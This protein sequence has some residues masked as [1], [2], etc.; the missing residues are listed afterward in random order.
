MRERVK[1]LLAVLAYWSGL[2]ALFY[3]LNRRSKRI[4]T[5]HNV[6]PDELIKW[7]PC[8]G[9]ADSASDFRRV[10]RE[11]RKHFRFSV[12]FSDASTL[13]ITFDDGYLNQY[14]IAARILREEGDIPAVLFAT[15]RALRATCPNEALIVDQLTHWVG[16]APEI[17]D[18]RVK[19]VRE[20][21]PAYARDSATKGRQLML[22]LDAVFPFNA[23]WEKLPKEYRRLRLTGIPLNK[24]DELRC[25]GWK[26]GWHTENHYPLSFL[27]DSDMRSEMKN[28][29]V[30]FDN[31]MSYP[32]GELISVDKRV[33]E[34]AAALGYDMAFSNQGRHNG[35]EGRYFYPREGVPTN[36]YLLHFALSGFKQFIQLRELRPVIILEHGEFTDKEEKNV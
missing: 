36:K 7:C 8:C 4:L 22:K 9:V 33:T 27:E 19:W 21:R 32:Y 25:R 14:E 24:L 23:I 34:M 28:R 17:K 6:I 16:L 15:G 18:R 3:W 31:I 35:L 11:L 5:F 13:T 29:L 10:I 20:I 12:D 26:I 30:G 1:F 2:D